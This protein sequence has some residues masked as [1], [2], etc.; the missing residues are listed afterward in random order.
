M[1][2]HIIYGYFIILHCLLGI[3]MLKSDFVQRVK[4][5]LGIISAAT[6]TGFT[7]QFYDSMVMFHQRMDGNVPSGSVVFIGDSLTQGLCVSAVASPA[8]NYGIGSDTTSGVIKRM[9]AYK[10][11]QRA[12]IIVFAI[13]F[14][15]MKTKSNELILKNYSEII[16]G[17]PPEVPLI[18]SA[19][20]PIDEDVVKYEWPGGRSGF[21]E[22]ANKLN[23][24]LKM[25]SEGSPRIHYVNA[26]SLLVDANGNL[27]DKFHCGDGIHLNSDGNRIWIQCLKTTIQGIQ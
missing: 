16:K 5:K 24:G 4:N 26:A 6:N 27:L 14:N 21:K 13:G 2:W 11:L 1:K 9:G 22:R 20:L 15:D 12:K 3:T 25:L 17:T 18:I 8:V 19:V 10:S 7:G 23:M